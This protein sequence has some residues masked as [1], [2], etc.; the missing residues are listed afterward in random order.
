MKLLQ[1]LLLFIPS[2]LNTVWIMIVTTVMGSLYIITSWLPYRPQYIIAR[3]WGGLC[4][5][6]TAIF[7]FLSFKV[8]GTVK[9]PGQPVIVFAKHQSAFEIF[10]LMRLLG[11]TSWVAKRELLR[12]PLFGWAFGLSKPICLD[13]SAGVSAVEQLVSQGKQALE[14]GRNVLIFP[15]GTR[16]AAGAEPNYRIGG[17][18]LAERSGYPILPVAHNAGEYWP[19]A[20]FFVWPGRARMIFGPLIETQGKKA[21][22]INREAQDWIE[23]RMAEI[24]DPRRWNR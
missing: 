18:L 16:K 7:C 19:R 23:G 21:A 10:E 20:S 8:T 3:T 22:A 1:R 13:R 2:L 24:S 17:A 12:L 11:P 9:T 5:V 6:G 4:T 14:A 15:E